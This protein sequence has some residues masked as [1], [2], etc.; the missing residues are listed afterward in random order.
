M[1]FRDHLKK[2]QDEVKTYPEWKQNILGGSM[3]TRR[4]DA[5]IPRDIH[6]KI[7]D[8]AA[9]LVGE[10]DPMSMAVEIVLARG[11][12]LSSVIKDLNTIID[13]LKDGQDAKYLMSKVA[14]VVVNYGVRDVAQG[15]KRPR[16]LWNPPGPGDSY[17]PEGESLKNR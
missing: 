5:R 2:S 14:G 8:L 6:D 16:G 7:R 4:I 10:D 1:T 15:T 3:P 17:A 11:L 13:Q 9:D 12:R